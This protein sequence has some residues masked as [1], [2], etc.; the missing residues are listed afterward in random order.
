MGNLSDLKNLFPDNSDSLKP[1]EKRGN[2]YFLKEY[3]DELYRNLLSAEGKAK[4]EINIAGVELRDSLELFMRKAFSSVGEEILKEVREKDAFNN[5][6]YTLDGYCKTAKN[7]PE[8]GIDGTKAII[9]KKIA[10]LGAHIE[11]KSPYQKYNYEELC[12][13]FKAF[14]ELL[15]KYYKS[16]SQPKSHQ[17]FEGDYDPDFQPIKDYIVYAVD[18][19]GGDDCE[20]QYQCYKEE[21]SLIYY[22]V[23]KQYSF[24]SLSDSQR[25]EMDSLNRIWHSSKYP[26][27]IV[28][29]SKIESNNKSDD[30]NDIKV[31]II[32]EMTGRPYKM[33]PTI[34]QNWNIEQKL[35]VLTLLTDALSSMHKMGI[36]HRNLNPNS[37]YTYITNDEIGINLVNFETAKDEKSQFTVLSA[38]KNKIDIN[39]SFVAPEVRSYLQSNSDIE[40]WKQADIYSLGVLF[41]YILLNGDFEQK[42][43]VIT[44]VPLLLNRL[45]EDTPLN[46]KELIKKMCSNSKKE[47]PSILEIQKTIIHLMA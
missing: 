24:N 46:L 33:S 25:R 42:G 6:H 44:R 15:V 37:I 2:F 35:E 36:C 45:P 38:A 9:T 27:G 43:R 22:Y 18:E 26:H 30:K 40:E 16:Y 8:I 5:D 31:F 32:Y 41:V 29:Y 20:K 7:H 17:V 23:I 1:T 10:N 14:R 11:S 4:T 28:K 47:R 13:A 19:C 39:S 21:N 34:I 3:D 12:K